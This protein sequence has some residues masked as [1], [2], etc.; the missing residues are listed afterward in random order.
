MGAAPG[1]CVRCD[2][3]VGADDI[4]CAYC[5][6]QLPEQPIADTRGDEVVDGGQGRPGDP[7]PTRRGRSA[8]VAG[9]VASLVAAVAAGVLLTAIARHREG[10]GSLADS[11]TDLAAITGRPSVAWSRQ[12]DG[13]LSGFEVTADR[14]YAVVSTAPGTSVIAIDMTGAELW[15]TDV[16]GGAG[17]GTGSI[18]VVGDGIAVL[19]GSALLPE[20]QFVML[21]AD[22]GRVRWSS[23]VASG[24]SAVDRGH[25]VGSSEDGDFRQPID[26]AGRRLLEPVVYERLFFGDDL[27]DRWYLDAGGRLRS[28]DPSTLAA[29]G[30]V[31]VD[32]SAGVS[33]VVQA[34]DDRTII[35][36][37]GLLV[38]L[39]LNGGD[40]AWTADPNVGGLT[41]MWR[42]G[43]DRF[44]VAGDLGYRTFALDASGP[45]D[46]GDVRSFDQVSTVQRSGGVATVVTLQPS[47]TAFGRTVLTV[48]GEDDGRL[49]ARGTITD[50][51][52]PATVAAGDVLYVIEMSLGGGYD[53]QRRVSA[54]GLTDVRELWTIQL[55]DGELARPTAAGI[56]V[57]STG[58]SDDV[59][60]TMYTG[61]G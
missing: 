49:V 38:G 2:N 36:V 21:D 14:V 35:A 56:A 13:E 59:V 41:G 48:F 51:I 19:S 7:S 44:V 46:L 42:L 45:R 57:V 11:P 58:G 5:N 47:A 10:S 17:T 32:S 12:I 3:P 9:V 1:A 20:R 61:E 37:G 52:S 34:D 39:P 40:D 28:V 26:E 15:R 54:Y 4:F 24:A 27:G 16:A 25:V 33:A 23:E 30:S 18:D 60:V 31:D 53:V 43:R 6:L 50:F 55:D 8:W 29:D 22:T